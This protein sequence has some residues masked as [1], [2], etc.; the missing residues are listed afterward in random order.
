MESYGS[1]G[2]FVT[3]RFAGG[4][5]TLAGAMVAK[6]STEPIPP[7]AGELRN[8]ER[9]IKRLDQALSQL[10]GRIEPVCRVE[11]P[12][13]VGNGVEARARANSGLGSQVAGYAD[14][15]DGLALR[16]D[17]LLRRCEL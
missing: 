5:G 10:A 13:P 14:Q 16:V 17:G 4:G 3:D 12:S 6:S 7:V 8:L 9:S 1:Q 15:I 11:P 2:D